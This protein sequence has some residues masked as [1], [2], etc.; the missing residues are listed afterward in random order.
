MCV[1]CV[2]MRALCVAVAQ[3][4][5]M[6]TILLLLYLLFTALHTL[7][8]WGNKDS[9]GLFPSSIMIDHGGLFFFGWQ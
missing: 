1:L 6:Y 7:L 4:S 5:R 9:D 2:L 3:T 8:L